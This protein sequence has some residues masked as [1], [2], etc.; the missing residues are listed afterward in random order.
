MLD[1]VLMVQ[2][3]LLQV[4]DLMMVMWSFLFIETKTKRCLLFVYWKLMNKNI[5]IKIIN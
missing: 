2:I 4:K 5:L 3:L 1:F